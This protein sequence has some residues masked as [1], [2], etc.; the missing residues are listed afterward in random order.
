MPL[1]S[2]STTSPVGDYNL[3]PLTFVSR[4]GGWLFRRRSWLPLPLVAALLLIPPA[5]DMPEAVADPLW[6]VGVIVVAVAEGVRLWAVHHIG[7]HFA[8]SENPPS[9]LVRSRRP[10][11]PPREH[12]AVDGSPSARGCSGSRVVV[13]VLALDITRCRWK[14]GCWPNSWRT[15]RNYM[16]AC[17]GGCHRDAHA[18]HHPMTGG[19]LFSERGDFDHLLGFSFWLKA[20][21]TSV[22][23]KYLYATD[24][25]GFTLRRLVSGDRALARRRGAEWRSRSRDRLPAARR[26]D[27]AGTSEHLGG[28]R[29][30]S[31]PSGAR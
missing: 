2:L 13:A 11:S 3:K 18:H 31:P 19:A 8:R 17:R 5:A 12:P 25:Y 26:A 14:N 21:F 15:V 4:A 6:A 22:C 28:P 23:H 10:Q 24:R 16:R 7:R 9:P 27:E 20:R 30:P 29:S 1:R